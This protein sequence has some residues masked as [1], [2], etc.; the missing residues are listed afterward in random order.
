MTDDLAPSADLQRYAR[1]MRYAP[2]G[3]EGQKRL[4]AGRALI[5]GC[6]ALGSV[7]ANTLVRAGV[8]FVR[9]VDRDFLELNNLQR[10]VLYDEQDVAE[11]LPKAVAAAKKLNKINSQVKVEPLVKDF[12]YT[13]A[14]ELC[15]GIDVVV[16]GTDNFE[17]RFLLNDV[18]ARHNIPWVYGGCIGAEG[19]TMTIVPGQTACFRCLMVEPPPPGS[20]PT[21]DTAGI[22]GGI[23]N[24]VASIQ[25]TEAIKLLTGRLEAISRCLTVIDLWDN[26]LRQIQLNGLRQSQDC[27][28]CTRR[29]FPWLDG[30]RGSHTSVLCGRNAVQLYPPDRAEL[31]LEALASQLQGVGQVTLNPFMLRLTVDDFQVTVFPD[32]RAIVGGTND[33]AEAKTLYARYIGN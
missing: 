16:D 21:C 14:A 27:P 26:Q 28:T 2:I 23:V 9:V 24:V 12:D 7:L 17:T 1:Q 5:C 33:V 32:G 29:E 10:Q 15:D 18:S 20:T 6:G 8:G 4:A 25:A 13:N 3:E 22:L 30:R 31:S 19:Q 11:G